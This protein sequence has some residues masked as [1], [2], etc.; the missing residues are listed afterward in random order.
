MKRKTPTM[1]KRNIQLNAK[2]QVLLD[3]LLKSESKDFASR[4]KEF[5]QFI[6][7]LILLTDK[8]NDANVQA[9]YWKQHLEILAAKFT[10]HSSSLGL[11]MKGTPIK[12]ISSGTPLLYPDIG[13]IFLLS[14]AHLEC[15]LMFY[16]LNV[17]PKTFEEGELRYL[18]YEVS[19][20]AHRQKN[21]AVMPEHVA[22]KSKEKKALDDMI[23]KIKQNTFFQ[24]LP[25]PKQNDL[26]QKK[27]AKI[28]GWEQLIISSHLETEYVLG[29]W[30]LQSN[31]AHSEMV[32]AIQMKGYAYS[33]KE[34]DE[35]LFFIL[36]RS[37]TLVAVMIKDLVKLF[38]TTEIT[39]IALP[40]PLT[41][42]INFWADLGTGVAK[43]KMK[44]S[45]I[46]TVNQ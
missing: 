43:K 8:L 17:Q 39:Y 33:R 10:L 30:R 35:M 44:A 27:Q 22:K 15:Y 42:K 11:L 45:P 32:S 37:I 6:E 9:E 28:M 4:F 40:F 36:E 41:T 31:Y 38:K 1:G 46:I 14:R 5:Q 16:Y 34:T 20:L 18:L 12:N 24:G 3:L 7:T 2:D 25:L 26:L 19:G 13:S 29:L 21:E 23:V